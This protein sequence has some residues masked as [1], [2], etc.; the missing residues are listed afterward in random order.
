[1][2]RIP[3]FEQYPGLKDALPCTSLT[4]L[5]TP[6]EKLEKL[7]AALGIDALY[8]KRDDLT[9]TLY[10][11]NKPRKLEFI[12]ADALRSGATHVLTFGAA[13]SNHSLATALYAQK[14]GLISI[15]MLVPQLNANYVRTNL[16]MSHRCGAELH[17]C[18]ASLES[19]LNKLLAYQST[20]RQ[21]IRHKLTDGRTPYRIPPGGSS[22]HGIAGYVNAGL[23]LA[24]QIAAGIVPVPDRIYV[25]CG[26][27]GTAAGLILGL[28]AG[29]LRSR[30][31]AVKVTTGPYVNTVN[32]QKC[33]LSTNRFLHALDPSFPLLVSSQEEFEVREGYSGPRYALFTEAGMSAV[34]QMWRNERLRLEGTYTG[35]TCAALLDDVRDGR[36]Q[37]MTVLFWNT[38][39]SRDFSTEIEGIDYHYLPRP[40]HAYFEEPVQPLDRPLTE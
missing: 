34:R 10:G 12:L 11:G 4:N 14:L 32:M 13:G 18:G 38:F 30:V 33:V 21:L 20:L 3:L 26:T 25:A 16:L 40:F 35:K 23:E 5:P 29:G 31:I 22:H 6:V 28:K 39:N 17:A 1:M 36:L 37:E 7:G 8:V 24:G 27:L 19:P 2:A 15:S 9:G